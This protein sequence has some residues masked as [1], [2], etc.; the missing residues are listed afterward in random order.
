[1]NGETIAV[2]PSFINAEGVHLM[3]RKHQDGSEYD[4][5]DDILVLQIDEECP[6]SIQHGSVGFRCSPEELVNLAHRIIL[7]HSNPANRARISKM[8]LGLNVLT[9]RMVF[10]AS[11]LAS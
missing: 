6:S 4:P 2:E 8:V 10:F 7:R 1:M 3:V 11:V 5:P 9:S